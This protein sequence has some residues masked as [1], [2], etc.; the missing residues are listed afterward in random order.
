MRTY[1]SKILSWI[2]RMYFPFFAILGGAIYVV[3]RLGKAE[4]LPT[5]VAYYM[6]DL[7]CMPIVLYIC[8]Y[9]VRWLKSDKNLNL[10][11]FSII[12]LTVFYSIYFEVYLPKVNIRYTADIFDVVM[13]FLG[14][15]FFYLIENVVDEVKPS[16]NTRLR[17][18]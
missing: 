9:A 6:N 8:R 11:V 1:S 14:A 18:N 2:K 7:L 3:Q 17:S 5:W 13:Y 16:R 12:S 10:T 4:I 15:A